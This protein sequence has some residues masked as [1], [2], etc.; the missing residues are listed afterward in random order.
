MNVDAFIRQLKEGPHYHNQVVHIHEDP[1]REATYTDPGRV[2][3]DIEALLPTIGIQRLYRHQAEA[4]RAAAHH[5]VLVTTGTASGKSLC[6]A[7]PILQ[8]FKAS[9]DDEAR[10]RALM[11]FPTK[12][13]TQDQHRAF[14]ELQQ[15]LD[16]TTHMSGVIDGDTP[17]PLRRK[18]R[19]HA[20]AILTNPDMLHTSIMPQHARWA[21]CFANL[22]FIILDELHTYNGIFGSNAALMFARLF[23][24]CRHYGSNPRILATS[25]T[26]ANPE[27]LGRRLTGRTFKV[28]KED[29]SPKGRR[30]TVFWNPPRERAGHW[31]S[32]RSANVEAHELMTTLVKQGC[33]TITFS[34]AKMTAEMI[35]RYVSESLE[36][37]RPGLCEKVTPYRGGYLP[38]ER[39]EIEHKLF[40]G[41]LLGVSTTSAL[42]LGIDVGGLDA[43]IVVGYPGTRASFFQQIGRAGRKTADAI[44][45]L[46]GLDTSINQYIMSAP[47]YIFD[48][49]IEHAV[50][51]PE[52]PFVAMGHARCAAFELAIQDEELEMFGPH[53]ASVLGVLEESRKLH[54][55][56]GRWYH[57][58][59]EV[60]NH[61]VSLRDTDEANV[62]IQD[63][64]SDK[65]LGEV[66]IY[67]APPLLHPG[68][69]YMH[70]GETWLV[71]ELDL[72]RRLCMLHREDVSYYTQPLGG[73][74]VHHIDHL[75]RRKP[76][77]G[78]TASW[79]EVTAYSNTYA[80][81]RV[82]FYQLDALSVHPLKLPTM[83]LETMAFWIE[84]PEALL[85]RVRA[86][87][88]DAHSGLRGIGYATRM[89]LPLFV[90]CDVR[91]F[92]HT[93]G[94]VN[95]DWSAVFIFER[96]PHGLG[97]TQH[98]Y[99]RLHEILPF[100]QQHIALCPC[101]AGCPC[102]VGK[103][104]RGQTTWN[105]ERGEASIPSKAA[106]LMI[107]DGLLQ[108]AES[109]K[110]PDELALAEDDEASERRL[111]Q[112]LKRRLERMREP[113][114]FH[115]ITPKPEVKA[116]YPDADASVPRTAADVAKRA[117]RRN[118][119]NRD[120][121][122]KL[123]KRIR[124]STLDPFKKKE[125]PPAGTHR[126]DNHLKPTAFPGTPAST[127][128]PLAGDEPLGMRSTDD[129]PRAP[130]ASPEK[131]VGDPLASRARLRFKRKRDQTT[132][133]E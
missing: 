131:A 63:V 85:N 54:H 122:K 95:S 83:Q 46:I 121:H 5:D 64:N 27:E 90:T 32:R 14:S 102:C 117:E 86:A 109:L 65:V 96:Y 38:E 88:L 4:I 126:S 53:A 119:F 80:Y 104:L 37:E 34:K 67:D 77:G 43:C 100:V 133:N 25:A 94:S 130:F 24:I 22:Q 73:T 98:A 19:D 72:G 66:D 93:V 115:R 10:P 55:L 33:P 125:G 47:D 8:A 82:R 78:G 105:V 70:L 129:T 132:N 69:V 106:A 18:L 17:A 113:T 44:A 15:V 89:A 6:Y 111:R 60:P 40:S 127:K 21:E 3:P 35:H 99:R 120:L 23:R 112:S 124:Q 45:F 76:F 36:K 50:I 59:S 48:R 97:F 75:L 2:S 26:I 39:R 29:T 114:V 79:G 56:D 128:A 51:D 61:E 11:L 1:A 123:A 7:L 103:P 116:A 30:V 52:N 12:A 87:N 110:R 71:D 9:R 31:R 62:L 91:D 81:E 107:L 92:S 57:A 41:E 101:E 42:E 16:L 28:I 13:L 118:Q 68:A 49:S 74:D 58:V 108:D 20:S 84:P